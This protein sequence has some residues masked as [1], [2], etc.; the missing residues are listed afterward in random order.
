[1][2]SREDV[3][4]EFTNSGSLRT[5]VRIFRPLYFIIKYVTPLALVAIFISNFIF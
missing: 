4:D 3:W 2:M 1:M 5:N